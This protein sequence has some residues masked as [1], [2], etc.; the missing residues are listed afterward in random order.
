MSLMF[1]GHL[2]ELELAGASVATS[3]ATVT[4]FSL[5]GGLS[6]SLETLC[7]QAFG[8][9]RHHQLGVY[10]QRAVLVL[11]V[12]SLPVAAAW[13]YTGEILAWFGQDPEIAAAAA[14]YIMGLIP[15]LLVYGPLNCHMRFLQTQNVVVPVMLAA[16]A[17]ARRT[18]PS[19]GSWCARSASA[20]PAPRWPPPSPTSPTSA[21]W[22]STSGCRRAAR[23]PGAAASLARRSA[24]SRLS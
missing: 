6:T 15:A 7:G 22:C 5:L 8:A 4:G 14:S 23:P 1:V 9:G 16:G 20:A 13:A 12:A 3:F 18:S 11:T 24:A 17:T 19:A 10:K 2:G 21:S